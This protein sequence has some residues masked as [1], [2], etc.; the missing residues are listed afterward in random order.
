MATRQF[1]GRGRGVRGWRTGAG[2]EARLG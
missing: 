1:G 2:C